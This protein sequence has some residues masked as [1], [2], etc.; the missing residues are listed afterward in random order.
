[1]GRKSN[2]SEV[3][4]QVAHGLATSQLIYGVIMAAL[5]AVGAGIHGFEKKAMHSLY[6]GL[7]CLMFMLSCSALLKFSNHKTGAMVAGVVSVAGELV[8]L[9]VFVLQ[10]VKS[11]T[12]P[13]KQDRFYL[14]VVMAVCTAAGLL[15]AFKPFALLMR[16]ERK[17]RK[18]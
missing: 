14:F 5:G 6:A 12:D 10:A 4:K 1:M 17:V 7:G 9:V 3:Q 16:R 2:L 18:N 15:M 8:C 11:R 13:A